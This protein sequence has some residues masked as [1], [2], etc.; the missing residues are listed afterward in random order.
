MSVTRAQLRI[1]IDHCESGG[2]RTESLFGLC[3]ASTRKVN[4]FVCGI[5]KR[6]LG[7]EMDFKF[8]EV[9]IR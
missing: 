1:S 9:V 3:V 7:V 6:Y 2:A 4:D 5:Y 8:F